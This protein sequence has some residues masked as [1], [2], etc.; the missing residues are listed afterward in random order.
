MKSYADQFEKVLERANAQIIALAGRVKD[1]EMAVAM[2]V[3]VQKILEQAGYDDMVAKFLDEESNIIKAEIAKYSGSKI[4]MRFAKADVSQVE[5]LQTKELLDLMNLK[6]GIAKK[7]QEI[8]AQGVMTMMSKGELAKQI[9][10]IKDVQSRYVTTYLE[11]ARNQYVQK[12]HDISADRYR[13]E[14]GNEVYWEYVGAPEDDKTRP[15]CSLALQKQYFTDAEKNDFQN[16]ALFDA[17]VPRWNCRHSFVE[18]TKETY[19]DR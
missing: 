15:E 2:R 7:V 12:L 18:I 4:P 1:I 11:T 16:G 19:N 8:T 6:E 10:M 5:A 14:T 13:S 17:K 3:E 9:G